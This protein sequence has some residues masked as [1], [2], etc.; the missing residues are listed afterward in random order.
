MFDTEIS[1]L[2]RQ[3]M[4]TGGIALHLGLEP[5]YVRQMVSAEVTGLNGKPVYI[6]TAA[7]PLPKLASAPPPQKRQPTAS[8]VNRRAAAEKRR[9]A[10]LQKLAEL[11]TALEA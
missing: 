2:S 4:T 7:E 6:D 9:A 1:N 10:I 5:Q 11:N 3:G 8:R